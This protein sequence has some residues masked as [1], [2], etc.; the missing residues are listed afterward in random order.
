MAVDAEDVALLKIKE[1]DNGVAHEYLG[2]LGQAALELSEFVMIADLFVSAEE[3]VLGD[4]EL[5]F[6]YTEQLDAVL[7]DERQ[8]L[9]GGRGYAGV[10]DQNA[11]RHPGCIHRMDHGLGR[12]DIELL[13]PVKIN[14]NLGLVILIDKKD[15]GVLLRLTHGFVTP[16]ID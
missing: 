15:V 2:Q 1:S 11:V 7:I 10:I 4:I 8:G 6:S 14:D 12:I 16:R 3:P 9:L 13:R 5:E